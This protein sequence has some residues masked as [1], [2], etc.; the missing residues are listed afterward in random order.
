MHS[1]PYGR[2]FS[3]NAACRF[4]ALQLFGLLCGI[5]GLLF[6]FCMRLLDLLLCAF[7]VGIDAFSFLYVGEFLIAACGVS[8]L[9]GR[10]ALAKAQG[11]DP[12][13]FS[14]GCGS[15]VA[16]RLNIKS[17]RRTA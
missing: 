12:N 6:L 3:V 4:D 1:L 16:V 17:K 5:A 7:R 15:V 8:P 11:L 9:R 14:F 13:A 10:P 2:L